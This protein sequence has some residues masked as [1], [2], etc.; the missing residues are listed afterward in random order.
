MGQFG[1]FDAEKL[2]R[3]RKTVR[4]LH[5]NRFELLSCAMASAA[6]ISAATEMLATRGRND[7][8]VMRESSQCYRYVCDFVD[9]G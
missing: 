1:F 4:R 9:I 6:N 8:C 7:V 2:R 3:N 5:P